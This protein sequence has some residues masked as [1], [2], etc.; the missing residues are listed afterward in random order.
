MLTNCPIRFY[1]ETAVSNYNGRTDFYTDSKPYNNELGA[2]IVRENVNLKCKK[3]TVN[4]LRLS[5]FVLNDVAQRWVPEPEQ[6]LTC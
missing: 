1:T 4:V 3:A 6:V 2:G 5:D